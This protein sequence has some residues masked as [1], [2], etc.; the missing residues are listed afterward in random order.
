MR[1]LSGPVCRSRAWA[2]P[3]ITA[4]A[5]AGGRRQP[6]FTLIEVLV[7][8]VILSIVMSAVAVG[9]RPSARHVLDTE[10]ERLAQLFELAMEESRYSGLPLAWEPASTGYRFLRRNDDGEWLP[11]G[12][13]DPL[14]PRRLPGEVRLAGAFSGQQGLAAGSRVVFRA[15]GG[16]RL[17]VRLVAETDIAAV[18]VHPLSGRVEVQRARSVAQP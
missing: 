16:E 11:P 14:R 6:G 8:L 4:T 2:P 17:E 12:G 7:V 5:L 13:D 3:H 9:I 10:T 18:I 1:D 15:S